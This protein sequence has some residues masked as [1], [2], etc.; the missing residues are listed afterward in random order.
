MVLNRRRVTIRLAVRSLA[1]GRA[2]STRPRP[3]SS[4]NS[5]S[6]LQDPWLIRSGQQVAVNAGAQPQSGRLPV[7][8]D[9]PAEPALELLVVNHHEAR[10]LVVS[11]T[12]F[13]PNPVHSIRSRAGSSASHLI[14]SDQRAGCI[15]AA[16]HASPAVVSTSS[17]PNSSSSKSRRSVATTAASARKFGQGLM[18]A[19]RDHREP[20]GRVEHLA[21]P[22]LHQ[23]CVVGHT[24]GLIML[25]SDRA[26]GQ[27]AACAHAP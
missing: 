17:R 21:G 22:F 19:L 25:P 5:P 7:G 20:S 10:E 1:G 26:Q 14:G 16:G 24:T 15:G 2:P 23:E 27:D 9:L 6:L 8:L 12:R 18:E 13:R 11:L 4:A 3:W